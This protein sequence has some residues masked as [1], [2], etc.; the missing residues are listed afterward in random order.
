MVNKLT[1]SK[2]FLNFNDIK[3]LGFKDAKEIANLLLKLE[4]SKFNNHLVSIKDEEDFI[5]KF[6]N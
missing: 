1:N 4:I 6:I 3:K 2:P 5:K